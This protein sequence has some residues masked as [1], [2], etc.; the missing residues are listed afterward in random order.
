MPLS[1]EFRGFVVNGTLTALSQYFAPCFFNEIQGREKEI[2]EKCEGLLSQIQH[3]IPKKVVCD[4]AVLEN[5]VMVIEINPFNDY[6]GCGT[7]A[8]MF[9]WKSDR[10]VLDGEAPFEFRMVK[11]RHQNIKSLVGN[12]WRSYF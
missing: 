11:E 10:A 1:A 5:T 7:S 12:E 8:C 4:F 3:L 9:D 2:R 6:T